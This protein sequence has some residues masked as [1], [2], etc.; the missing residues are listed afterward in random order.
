MFMALGREC[1]R[2]LPDGPET[3]V[4]LRKLLEALDWVERSAE[5]ANNDDADEAFAI[6]LLALFEQRH[7][8]ICGLNEEFATV[9]SSLATARGIRS[10]AA[11][12]RALERLHEARDA[13]WRA[14]QRREWVWSEEQGDWASRNPQHALPAGNV[15]E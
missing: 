1:W 3:T 7:K 5:I 12:C 8:D 4:C 9:A 11:L 2:R 15:T 6:S 14:R 13:A 10:H